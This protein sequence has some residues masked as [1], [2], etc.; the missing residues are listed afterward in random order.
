MG[1]LSSWPF[2]ALVHHII[3]WTAF[4]SRARSFRKYLILGDDIVIF[5]KYAYINYCKIL[6]ELG[7]GYTNN[8]SEIGFEFAKRVFVHGHEVTGAY[9]QAL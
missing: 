7:L 2:M 4:G 5:E 9:T 3:V 1:A 6:D 8:S